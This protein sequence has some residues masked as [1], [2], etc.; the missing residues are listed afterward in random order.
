MIAFNRA[1][2]CE[3]DDFGTN[4]GEAERVM[5]FTAG[6][7]TLVTSEEIEEF[8]DKC[9]VTRFDYFLGMSAEERLRVFYPAKGQRGIKM[10]YFY[11]REKKY[12]INNLHLV[13]PWKIRTRHQLQKMYDYRYQKE[14]FNF[15]KLLLVFLRLNLSIRG[16]VYYLILHANLFMARVGLEWMTR[17]LRRLVSVRDAEIILG[18]MIGCRLKIIETDAVGSTLDIDKE[19]DYLAMTAMFDQWR[20]SQQQGVLDPIDNSQQ[21]IKTAS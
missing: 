10:A 13:K 18:D 11:V 15:L 6:D 2:G 12:R 8:I 16:I 14:F 1:R 7:T 9:D 20:M 21:E 4:G 3:R 17:P 5:L 19:S